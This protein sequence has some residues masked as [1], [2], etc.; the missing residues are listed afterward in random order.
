MSKN[1]V[2]TTWT[3]TAQTI[4]RE[5]EETRVCGLA[6]VLAHR[7][8]SADKLSILGLSAGEREQN[9]AIAAWFPLNIIHKNFLAQPRCFT[10]EMQDDA[11]FI[12]LHVLVHVHNTYGRSKMFKSALVHV[13]YISC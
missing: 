6:Q 5:R 8:D 4:S 2:P 3:M 9:S 12:K 1:G 13:N 10:N 11:A 7:V